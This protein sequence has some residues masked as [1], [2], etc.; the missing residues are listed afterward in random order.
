MAARSAASRWR[1]N[2]ASSASHVSAR[3]QA[4]GAPQVVANRATSVVL[5]EPAGA[6]TSVRRRLNASAE[7]R[8]EALPGQGLGHGDAHLRGHDQRPVWP[9]LDL[10][11]LGRSPPPTVSIVPQ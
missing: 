2:E 1:T 11:R 7:A 9:R 8:L 6:T 3:Y 10:A 4:T 5:P